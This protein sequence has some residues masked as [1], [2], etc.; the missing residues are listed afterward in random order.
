M[1]RFPELVPQWQSSAQ[2]LEELFKDY[3]LP[4]EAWAEQAVQG[5]TA[6]H[7]RELKAVQ[8]LGGDSF[9]V[10]SLFR[11]YI[12]SRD[13][14]DHI[15]QGLIDLGL[16]KADD[17]LE[18]RNQREVMAQQIAWTLFLL[19]WLNGDEASK[20]TWATGFRDSMARD[21][22][23][24]QIRSRGSQEKSREDKVQRF[25]YLIRKHIHAA[26]Q[27]NGGLKESSVTVEMAQK[28][29]RLDD[30]VLRSLGLLGF[31]PLGFDPY[32]GEGYQQARILAHK[33]GGLYEVYQVEYA[34]RVV[35]KPSID[36]A[37]NLPEFHL[38]DFYQKW[39][40][41]FN[42]GALENPL[43]VGGAEVQMA[44]RGTL[45][46]QYQVRPRDLRFRGGK[47][48]NGTM[49]RQAQNT[50]SRSSSYG[51]SASGVNG[52]ESGSVRAAWGENIYM[53]PEPLSFGS[54]MAGLP[55]HL[56]L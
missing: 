53:Q 33:S 4:V 18:R 21:P 43:S 51:A 19:G 10:S 14:T 2:K 36:N 1:L 34:K 5:F 26:L 55:R 11:D 15:Y 56:L 24:M 40:N 30:F 22:E 23:L 37:K 16:I 8:R 49:V 39:C 17:Y 27:L 25:H 9:T 29:K 48:E 47:V 38:K 50:H 3:P 28:F 44:Y 41:A 46:I 35:L 52:L 54:M 20:S 7:M 42:Q 12:G 13:L 32:M 31:I 45:G 6:K